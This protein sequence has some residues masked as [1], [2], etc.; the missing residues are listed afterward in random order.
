MKNLRADY[1]VLEATSRLQKLIDRLKLN[2][3]PTHLRR[4]LKVVL[5]ILYE[6]C[7]I[8][9]EEEKTKKTRSTYDH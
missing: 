5:K 4:E 8:I 7:D 9:M 2:N 6:L 1:R 3:K